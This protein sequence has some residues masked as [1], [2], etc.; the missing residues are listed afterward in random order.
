AEAGAAPVVGVEDGKPPG[1]QVLDL[2]VD[3]VL[4]VPG[5]PAMDIDDRAPVLALRPVE[6]ALDLEPAG[7]APAEILG[8]GQVGGGQRRAV[9]DAGQ[10]GHL[11]HP[12][13]VEGHAHQVGG[14]PRAV[15][16]G[17]PFP[18][19]ALPGLARR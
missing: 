16:L 19:P 6:P 9:P 4:A 15:D 12:V 17:H 18:A 14:L 8:A 11:A 3:A 7:A 13:A 10:A 2:A 5:G 1:D